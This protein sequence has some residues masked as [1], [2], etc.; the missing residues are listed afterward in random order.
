MWDL[1]NRALE[2]PP[3]ERSAFLQEACDGDDALQQEV[4]SLL[5]FESG[6]AHFLEQ[7]PSRLPA[8]Q[9]PSVERRC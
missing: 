9:V 6:A 4:E 2:R 3:K 7:P 8:A 5:R 1:Y